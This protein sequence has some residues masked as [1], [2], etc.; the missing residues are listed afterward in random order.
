MWHELKIKIF[1]F[2]KAT[3]YHLF[4][5]RNDK[6]NELSEEVWLFPSRKSPK[7]VRASLKTSVFLNPQ[8]G[9]L[10]RSFKNM[11]LSRTSLEYG[12]R[13]SLKM[14][15]NKQFPTLPT[16]PNWAFWAKAKEG[17]EV[18]TW[19]NC[20]LLRKCSVDRW[21]RNELLNS[22]ITGSTMKAKKTITPL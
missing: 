6:D 18:K 21:N 7:A 9:M 4:L 12:W 10:T 17:T 3:F 14:Y 16:E 5:F 22:L 19:T 13:R 1:V 20:I 11:E 2:Q 8:W 15:A